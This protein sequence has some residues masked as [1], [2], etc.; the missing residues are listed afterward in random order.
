MRDVIGQRRLLETL[1]ERALRGDVAHAYGLSG[2]RS[3]GKRTVAVRLAQT[4]NCATEPAV[5]GGCGRCRSCQLIERGAHPDVLVVSRIEPKRDISIEQV[6]AMQAD[7]SLRPLEG[8]WRVASVDDAADLGE[9]AEVALLKTLEEPPRHAMLLLLTPSP[10][11]LLHTVRSR[12][13]ALP[14]RLVPTAEIAAALAKRFG[15]GAEKHAAAGAGR[16]G[17]AITLASEETARSERKALEN[18]LFKLMESGLTD[19]FAWA[20]DLADDPDTRRRMLEIERR[21]VEW[22]ELLR[23]AALVSQQVTDRAMRPER[24]E[25]VRRIAGAVG[26]RELVDTA[27]LTVRLARDVTEWSANA[28]ALLELFA[29]KL[30]YY[31]AAGEVAGRSRHRAAVL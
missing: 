29:L 16:P 1:G 19:R 10:E 22:S 9:H 23:D 24:A 25:D 5:P 13:Q 27:S 31:A 20:A 7:L 15:K 17:L 26:S 2:P 14:F 18:E 21:M 28:R 11:R 3:I 6:R 30:P 4:L 12:I 8:R